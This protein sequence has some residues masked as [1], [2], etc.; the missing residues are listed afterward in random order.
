MSLISDMDETEGYPDR[1]HSI[2]KIT[3][4][5]KFYTDTQQNPDVDHMAADSSSTTFG[6]FVKQKSMQN[7]RP[8]F[9]GITVEELSN[10]S[11]RSGKSNG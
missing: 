3:N 8:K 5:K 11:D 7:E 2:D 10:M 1:C 4:N 9:S 6:K